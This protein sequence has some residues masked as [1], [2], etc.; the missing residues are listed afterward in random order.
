MKKY[1]IFAVIFLLLLLVT[2]PAM[3][4]DTYNYAVSTKIGENYVLYYGTVNTTSD[5]IGNHYT[6]AMFIQELTANNA[7]IWAVTSN[8]NTGT[9]KVDVTAQ[10]SMD[11]TTWISSTAAIDGL[12]DLGATSVPDTIN[13]IVGARQVAYGPARWM[14][15]LFD[16]QAGNT[17][18]TVTW[19]VLLRKSEDFRGSKGDQSWYGVMD[20]L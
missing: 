2:M 14:R 10:Y 11:R 16:G 8:P 18:C 13:V 12:N 15:I 1:S 5:S 4:G 6:Q 9:E 20:K 7:Y 17:K 3:A 19:Y